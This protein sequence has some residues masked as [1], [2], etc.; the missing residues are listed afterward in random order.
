MCF[1]EMDGG[2][3]DLQYLG[4]VTA[5]HVRADEFVREVL[6]DYEVLD[7]LKV[8]GLRLLLERNEDMDVGV[9]LYS[10]YRRV[11]LYRIR[12]GRKRHRKFVEGY[13]KVASKFAIIQDSYG[14]KLADAAEEL[15]RSLEFYNSLDLIDNT[16]DCACAIFLTAGLKELGQDVNFIASAFDADAAKA[17][18]LTS[19]VLSA[20][21]ELEKGSFAETKKQEEK[22]EE[23]ADEAD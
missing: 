2:D 13:A 1:D 11:P 9:V 12:I 17:R 22:E 18:V 21:A 15:Y 4:L 10:I 3:H 23:N 6:L 20:R 7:V 5:I 8:E 14:E 16:D 19:Y